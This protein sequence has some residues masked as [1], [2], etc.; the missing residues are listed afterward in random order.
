MLGVFFSPPWNRDI[1]QQNS[2]LTRIFPHKFTPTK[3]RCRNPPQ[4]WTLWP[5][6]LTRMIWGITSGGLVSTIRKNSRFRPS[7]KV[8]PPKQ[9]WNLKMGAPWKFGDSY[10]FHH[11]FQVPGCSC[12]TQPIGFNPFHFGPFR[13]RPEAYLLGPAKTHWIMKVNKKTLA[14]KKNDDS[15]PIVT[16]FGQDLT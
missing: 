2:P 4:G 6:G 3:C 14:N 15:F 13:W 1:S 9:T 12:L 5:K 16:G 11:H 10:W 7:K 8:H